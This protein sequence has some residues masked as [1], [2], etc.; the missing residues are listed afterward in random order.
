MR[1]QLI[2]MFNF[3]K[4]KA[5]TIPL[6]S[7][8]RLS[9]NVVAHYPD[10]KTQM[11]IDKY[12]SADLL[13]SVVRFLATTAASIPI[14]EYDKNDEEIE[15]SVIEKPNM[16]LSKFEFF[17][18]VYTNLLLHGESFIAKTQSEITRSIIDMKPLN[19]MRVVINSSPIMIQSYDY[20]PLPGESKTSFQPDEVIHVKYFNPDDEMRGLSPVKVL[21]KAL[22]LLTTTE[23]VKQAQMQNG[24]LD[25]IVF[26]KTIDGMDN[27]ST[28]TQSRKANFMKFISD[29]S[30]KGVPYFAQGDMGSVKL[31]NTLADLQVLES[32]KATFKRLCNVYGTSDILFNSDS[33]A[34]ES[35]VKEMIKRTYTNTIIPNVRRLV[36][37]LSS[38]LGID[39]KY[40]LSEIPELQDD[41]GSLI[42][43]LNT[44]YWLTPNEKREAMKYGAVAEP[45]FDSYFI[46]NS[47][48]PIDDLQMPEL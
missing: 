11:V 14:Y 23:N 48:R 1:T 36:D 40:D 26:E 2:K 12:L 9:P 35:N 46:P 39:L 20:L 30:N 15:D 45:I 28:I 6:T 27:A 5:L 21:L 13:Y 33:S 25:S 31:G 19:P 47:V 16:T 29:P 34:T 44:A 8:V 18:Q 7:A 4:R 38:S 32:E 37:S 17:E 3:L 43:S 24:G 42:D 22:H 10:F 41:M